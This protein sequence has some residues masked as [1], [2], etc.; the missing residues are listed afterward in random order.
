VGWRVWYCG[1]YWP[2]VHT[3]SRN[4][5]YPHMT[6]VA[7]SIINSHVGPLPNAARKEPPMNVYFMT[8]IY[9]AHEVRHEVEIDLVIV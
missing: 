7:F 1:H 3:L 6:F 5:A 4:S 2:C 8:K 9:I